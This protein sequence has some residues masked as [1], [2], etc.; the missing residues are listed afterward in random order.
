MTKLVTLIPGDG[1]GPEISQSV[2]DIFAAAKAPIEWQETN[3]G[4][5]ALQATGVLV[6]DAVISSLKTTGLALKGPT[7]TPIGEGH[8]SI[9]VELRQRFEL[10]ANVR[11]VYSIAGVPCQ[12]KDV[13]MII[14]RE[15][16]E[17]LYRGIEYKIGD[18]VAHGIKIITA[19]ASERIAYHAFEMATRLGRKK[20]TSVHKANI[21]KLTDG[22]FLECVRRVAAGFKGIEYTE[23]IVDNCCMQM[24]TKPQ[25][26]DVIVTENLYGDIISDLASGLIGGLGVA[27]GANIGK[28]M[29]IFEA[30]HG[31]APDIAGKDIANPTALLLSALMMLEHIG[32]VARATSIRTALFKTL[33]EASTRTRDLGGKLGTREFTAAVIKNL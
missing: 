21:M 16:T 20:V 2:R 26:F 24:V 17:D 1:I 27:A 22:L 23:V 18:R 30:V 5:A 6:S 4:L 15:N 11:P 19:D 31:S 3:A 25:Q 8:R 29:A 7:T 32:D 28:D 33:G 9:N 10:Y 14:V 12:H 13:N